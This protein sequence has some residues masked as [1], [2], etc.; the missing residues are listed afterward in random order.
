MQAAEKEGITASV[1]MKHR[2]RQLKAKETKVIA[3]EGRLQTL[4]D[5]IM[6]IAGNG[7]DAESLKKLKRLLKG[8]VRV[9]AA[10]NE[11]TLVAVDM[12]AWAVQQ[13]AC[14]DLE[15]IMRAYPDKTQRID[16]FGTL[17]LKD[18]HSKLESKLLPELAGGGA[19]GTAGK[20]E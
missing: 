3:V 7:A 13:R 14:D 16:I 8:P 12:E 15:T 2:K 4:E 10:S 1:L 5:I 19:Q 6:L 9:L 20:P 11:R 18:A 17:E